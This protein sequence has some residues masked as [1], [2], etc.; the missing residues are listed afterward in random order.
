MDKYAWNKETGRYGG[1]DELDTEYRLTLL[2]KNNLP[3]QLTRPQ[4]G[5]S[6]STDV[7]ETKFVDSVGGVHRL[8][9]NK[10]GDVISE[11]LI[12]IV[13]VWKELT[14]EETPKGER[15][16]GKQ[17]SAYGFEI[18]GVREFKIIGVRKKK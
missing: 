5:R 10:Q 4:E 8:D 6:N 1:T 15:I 17:N 18:L 12:P 14:N 3:G 16:W 13:G 11:M 2:D 9:Y 7:Y